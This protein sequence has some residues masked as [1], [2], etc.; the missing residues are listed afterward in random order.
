MTGSRHSLK[1]LHHPG[2]ILIQ[3]AKYLKNMARK[4][5]PNVTV[6]AN[7][8][9][10][11]G[12][13][14]PRRSRVRNALGRGPRE[15]G[16]PPRLGLSDPLR[17]FRNPA[18]DLGQRQALMACGGKILNGADPIAPVSLM[19]GT[20]GTNR[21][22]AGLFPR[23]AVRLFELIEA[24]RFREGL[25]LWSRMIPIVNCIRQM[26]RDPVAPGFGRARLLRAQRVAV[27]DP[28]VVGLDR[29]FRDEPPVRRTVQRDRP[30]APH[31]S[32]PVAD[33]PVGE[34]PRMLPQRRPCRAKRAKTT[35]SRRS[36]SSATRPFSTLW[37]PSASFM[38][39][40]PK[41]RPSVRQLRA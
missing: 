5:P 37:K 9:D 31:L 19:L 1:A 36:R 8:G 17:I 24:G 12:R 4:P 16:D 40:Q 29:A 32:R 34:I 3:P 14:R 27:D 10:R 20:T 28:G 6:H 25:D 35:P 11:D 26:D 22:R 18:G 15:E 38:S 33:H 2:T 39:G 7:T 23:E 30:A 13:V 21:G 41:R